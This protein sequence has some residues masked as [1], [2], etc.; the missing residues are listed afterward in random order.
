MF[1]S[2]DKALAA[3]VAAVIYW[4][5]LLFFGGGLD[6]GTISDAVGPLV[7]SIAPVL[8]WLFPNAGFRR[9]A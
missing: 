4:V 1:S 9:E 2:I 3:T 5:N 6:V 7:V 8:V